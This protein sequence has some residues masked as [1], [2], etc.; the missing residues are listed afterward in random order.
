MKKALPLLLIALVLAGILSPFT[1]SLPDGLEWIAEKL[2]FDQYAA[3][4]PVISSP[5][6]DYAVP[7]LGDS[8]LSTSI[9]GIAGT[10]I[11]FLLPFSFYLFRKK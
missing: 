3:E 6:P 4:E 11:C 8:P 5:L 2:G 10:L 7:L 9:A 1:S